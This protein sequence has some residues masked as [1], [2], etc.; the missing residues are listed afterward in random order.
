MQPAATGHSAKY[1]QDS[2][3]SHELLDPLRRTPL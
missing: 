3:L 2:T 1:M